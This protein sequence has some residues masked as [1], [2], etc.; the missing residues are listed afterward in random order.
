VGD[1]NKLIAAKL[2]C[3]L[4]TAEVH[5]TAL[6]RKAGSA[7]RTELVARLMLLE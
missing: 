5:V 3:A 1:S 6:L 7:T 4:R 2:G